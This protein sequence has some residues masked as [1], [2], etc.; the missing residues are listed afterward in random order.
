[1]KLK[2]NNVRKHLIK[3]ML[4]NYLHSSNNKR[5][6]SLDSWETPGHGTTSV[7]GISSGTVQ[8]HNSESLV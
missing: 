7:C 1:M 3:R 5:T 2:K 6:E 8:G 4:Y